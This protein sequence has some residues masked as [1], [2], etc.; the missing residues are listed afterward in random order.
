MYIKI[1]CARLICSNIKIHIYIK[2][3]GERV[4]NIL[5]EHSKNKI[6]TAT[7]FIL[8]HNKLMDIGYNY[9]IHMC[10]TYGEFTTAVCQETP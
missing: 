9:I 10:N 1:H 4:Q 7:L 5:I 3:K 8:E 6:F 2:S